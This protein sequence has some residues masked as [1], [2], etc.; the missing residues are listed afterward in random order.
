MMTTLKSKD[1]TAIAFVKQGDGA[2]VILV[3]GALSTRSSGSK[4]VFTA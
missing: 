3:D 1:E 4:S 2:A